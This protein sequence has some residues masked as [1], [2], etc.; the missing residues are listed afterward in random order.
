MN[1]FLKLSC[2]GVFVLSMVACSKTENST[3][4]QAQ[5]STAPAQVAEKPKA[6]NLVSVTSVEL[7]KDYEENTVAADQK[8]K[9]KKFKVTGSITSIDTD[10]TGAPYLTLTG[11]NEFSNPQFKFDE[12]SKG[13]IASLKKGNKVT[14][15]CEGDGDVIKTAMSKDCSFVE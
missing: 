1:N 4:N 6:E 10:F 2:I 7:S 15:I 14:L 11:F 12:D 13:K 3:D 9:G 5:N 8:Y